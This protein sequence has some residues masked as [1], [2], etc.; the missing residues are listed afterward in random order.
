M[1]L[2]GKYLVSRSL[3][4][5]VYVC[6]KECKIEIGNNDKIRMSNKIN[7][8]H[9][10]CVFLT[11]LNICRYCYLLGIGFVLSFSSCVKWK[12]WVW[13]RENGFLSKLYVCMW[14]YVPVRAPMHRW[15]RVCSICWS[16]RQI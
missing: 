7:F 2:I 3:T 8:C 5:E 4:N 6:N 13:S 10:Y 9:L 11:E 14:R 15:Q 16:C 1:C 12:K